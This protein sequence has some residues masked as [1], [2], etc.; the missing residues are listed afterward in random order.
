MDGTDY[1][2]D[3]HCPPGWD[4][5]YWFDGRNYLDSLPNDAARDLS[6]CVLDAGEIS[7]HG[8]TA[9]FTAAHRIADK[10][11]DFL[12][13]HKDEDFFLVVSI[14]EPHHPFICPEP[15]VSGFDEFTIPVPNAK[16]DLVNKPRMQR[17]WADHVAPHNERQLAEINGEVRYRS[18]R[19]F[20]CNS[21]SDFEVGRVI[22]AI[23]R[24]APE[25]L[26]VYTADHGDMLGSHRLIGKGPAMY[27]EVTR[28]PLIVRWPLFAPAGSVSSAL[29]SH[30]D[31]TPTFLQYFGIDVPDL[32]QGQ[33][34][35]SQFRTPNDWAADAIFIEFN[36]FEI[37]HD[38]FGAFSPIRCIFDGRFKLAINLLDTDELYDLKLDPH[39][40]TNLID[41]PSTAEIRNLL[42]DRVLDWM[43]QTRDPLR[44]PHWGRRS[45]RLLNKSTWDGP[46]RPRPFDES[47]YPR[48]LLYETG[49]VIDRHTYEKH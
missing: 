42:H 14:D 18:P 36:R 8:V 34:M 1:F 12:A 48:T 25:A 35:L 37:D 11:C 10:A 4:S 43:N 46:T 30:V 24:H 3:G 33:S 41:D 22:E 9:E 31:L 15:F 6:R 32:L 40:M 26:V 49:R 19:Y 7:R 28:V 21:F 39:E 5:G 38:G 44:G 13:R 16:D 27:E 45:W 23:D 29:M 47:Y 17:E 2:G 20:A